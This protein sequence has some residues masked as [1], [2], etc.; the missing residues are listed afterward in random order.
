M[1]CLSLETVLA[2]CCLMP[3]PVDAADGTFDSNG[4]TIRY[5]T[6]GNGKRSS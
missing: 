3:G 4:V 2:V 6:E 1:K 5:V